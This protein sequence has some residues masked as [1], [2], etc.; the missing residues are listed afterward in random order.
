MAGIILAPETEYL[1]AVDHNDVP[2]GVI[3]LIK[4]PKLE[5][6]K[7]A[8]HSVT[9]NMEKGAVDFVTKVNGPRGKAWEFRF[10]LKPFNQDGQLSRAGYWTGN[11]FKVIPKKED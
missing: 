5:R 3:P 9:I 2:K 4:S 1:L 10:A 11:Y 7:V 8:E 6:I